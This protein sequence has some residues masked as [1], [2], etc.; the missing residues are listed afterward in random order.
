MKIKNGESFELELENPTEGYE[1]KAELI[2][3]IYINK[4]GEAI[5]T[6]ELWRPKRKE[7]L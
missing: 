6:A 7:N 3:K 2:A 5:K 4:N 1:G